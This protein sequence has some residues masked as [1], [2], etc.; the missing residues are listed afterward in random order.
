MN[1]NYYSKCSTRM[2]R[3]L[4]VEFQINKKPFFEINMFECKNEYINFG[5][6][7]VEF[8]PNEKGIRVNHPISINSGR[9][10][11]DM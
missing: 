11:K 1:T 2:L 9:R 6:D 10:F 5:L 7:L 3:N 8:L 4:L